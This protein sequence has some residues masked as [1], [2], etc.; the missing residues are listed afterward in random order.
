MFAVEAGCGTKRPAGLPAAHPEPV[1]IVTAI[2]EEFEALAKGVSGG[3]RHR[4]GNGGGG[5]LLRGTMA[6][7]SVRLGMTGDGATRASR[8]LQYLFE[9]SPVSLLVG[10]G[11]AGALVPSLLAGDLVVSRRVIDE[12][13]EAPPPDASLV[14]RTLALGAK[15]ATF[16]TAAGPLTSS[17]QKADLAARVGASDSA[18]A[19][20][21]MESSAW[22]RAAAG[23]GVPYVILRAISDTCDEELPAFLSSCLGADGS[24]DRAAVARRLLVHPGALP[25]L[26]AM[27]RRVVAASEGLGRFLARFLGGLRSGSS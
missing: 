16:V 22:A 2:R 11:V 21:D 13:G 23:Q 8:S 5:W 7:A 24:V 26:L 9:E 6:G 17:S 14:A 10:A 25:A 15:P 18:P 4:L 27:R 3:Q 12:G 19:V 20:V 1:A